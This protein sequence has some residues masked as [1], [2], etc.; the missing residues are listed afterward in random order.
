MVKVKNSRDFGESEIG[1]L[2]EMPRTAIVGGFRGL[3]IE[4]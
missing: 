4:D 1:L 3:L 2:R